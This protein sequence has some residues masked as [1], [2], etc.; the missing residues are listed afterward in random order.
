M[1]DWLNYTSLSVKAESESKILINMD[2]VVGIGGGRWLIVVRARHHGHTICRLLKIRY[3]QSEFQLCGWECGCGWR[4]FEY[5]QKKNTR[6]SKYD[7]GLMWSCH[8][9]TA[10][11]QGN[12]SMPCQAGVYV[13]HSFIFFFWI[14]LFC[15]T[16][17]ML[18]NFRYKSIFS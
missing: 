7:C 13:I 17:W 14:A 15:F 4:L 10:L 5:T 8:E 3:F 6:M 18:L 1:I 9:T 16:W 11:G 12:G 2:T